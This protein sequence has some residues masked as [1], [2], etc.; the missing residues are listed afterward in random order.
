MCSS[1]GLVAAAIR[2]LSSWEREDTLC[3]SKA[4]DF[5][6]PTRIKMIWARDVWNSAV[7]P[8]HAFVLWLS[9]K[10]KLLTKDKLHFLDIDRSCGLCGTCEETHQ[11]VFF[12]CSVSSQIWG[13]D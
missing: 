6:R 4:Y 12:Q 2:L 7:M 5:F 10:S 11:H 1:E 3:L 9:V 8:K 13:A